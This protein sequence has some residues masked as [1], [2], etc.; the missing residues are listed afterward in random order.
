M[1]RFKKTNLLLLLGV[2]FLMAAVLSLTYLG[3]VGLPSDLVTWQDKLSLSLETQHL[4]APYIFW[5]SLVL[6]AALLLTLIIISV[7]PS[8]LRELR[9]TD[10]ASGKLLLKPSALEGYVRQAVEEAGVMTAPKVAVKLG[11]K[12]VKVDVSGQATRFALA[13]Q[14]VALE[15]AILAGLNDFF[16]LNH[17]LD[18]AVKVNQIAAKQETAKHRVV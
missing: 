14:F 6:V 11:K 18:L 15:Q 3:W 13:E 1:T 12:K 8:A 17:Q 4:I 16:G 2:S 5:P 7:Y 10:Q 9:L